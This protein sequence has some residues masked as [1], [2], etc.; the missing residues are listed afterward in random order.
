MDY[1]EVGNWKAGCLSFWALFKVPGILVIGKYIVLGV[2]CLRVFIVSY[3]YVWH[4]FFRIWFAKDK[5]DKVLFLCI[6]NYKKV[7]AYMGL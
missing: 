7:Y 5:D 4:L 2:S 1:V 6:K 3:G